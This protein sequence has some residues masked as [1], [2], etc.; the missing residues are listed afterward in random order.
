MVRI[1]VNIRPRKKGEPGQRVF[2]EPS[3]TAKVESL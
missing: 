2:A 1:E 3:K